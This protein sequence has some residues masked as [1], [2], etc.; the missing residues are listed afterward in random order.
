[1]N[2]QIANKAGLLPRLHLTEQE[3]EDLKSVEDRVLFS[4]TH[5]SA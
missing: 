5:F 3:K 1:L 4:K 2:I